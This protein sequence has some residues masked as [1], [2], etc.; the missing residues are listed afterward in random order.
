M[1]LLMTE[2]LKDLICQTLKNNGGITYPRGP[3]YLHTE[4]LAE[5]ML[6]ISYKEIGL[7]ILVLGPLGAQSSDQRRPLVR[8]GSVGAGSAAGAVGC[9]QEKLVGI[10]AYM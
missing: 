1:K 6:I 7:S 5:T 3:K 2:V 4:Y 10:H 8:S 9:S